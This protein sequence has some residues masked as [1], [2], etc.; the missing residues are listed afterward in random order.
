M[1]AHEKTGFSFTEPTSMPSMN[2]TK[3]FE[4]KISK[5]VLLNSK[6]NFIYS[7]THMASCR[8]FF[9]CLLKTFPFIY[10][11]CDQYETLSVQ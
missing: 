7:Y 3:R 4:I 1:V 9:T 11:H 5:L 10:L 6:F 2:K 8:S